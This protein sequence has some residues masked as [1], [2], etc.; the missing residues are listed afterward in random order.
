MQCRLIRDL[1]YDDTAPKHLRGQPAPAGS[2]IEGP[3]C[4]QIVTAGHA[5]PHD[6]E[7]ADQVWRDK[8]PGEPIED[9]GLSDD[10]LARLRTCV[11]KLIRNGAAV[12]RGI[13]PEDYEDFYAGRMTGY[14]PETGEPIPGENAEYNGPL[15]L[16]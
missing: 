1:A 3:D 11:E 4:W 13:H 2:V 16:N 8:F 15:I 10:Q 12:A 14:D 5:V 9:G 6:T 7:C